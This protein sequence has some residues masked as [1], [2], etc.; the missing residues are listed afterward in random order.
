MASRLRKIAGLYV[1]FKINNHIGGLLLK[2][3]QNLKP[4]I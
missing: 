2:R 1:A 3:G 4:G